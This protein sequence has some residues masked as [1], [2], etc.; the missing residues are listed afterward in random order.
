VRLKKLLLL[1][2]CVLLAGCANI[3]IQVHLERPE[4]T[5]TPTRPAKETP[6][7]LQTP[8]PGTPSATIPAPKV[9]MTMGGASA[10]L[11]SSNRNGDYQDLYLQ[12]FGTNA[13]TRLTH[14]DAN[15]FPGP[16]SPDG[17]KLLFT[18]FGLTNSYVGVSNADGS[19]PVDLTALPDV[20]R[21]FPRLVPRWHPHC[22]H[23][24]RDGNNEI[25][26]MDA[27]GHNL[28]RLTD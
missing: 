14:G 11:F 13:I 1:T 12:E 17:K 26:L 9:P 25:Y 10:I 20:S 5:P 23:L 24:H 3:G 22:L 28:R 27:Y 7:V 4:N 21:W 15:T 19:D 6:L 16:F 18:G 8:V 2:L